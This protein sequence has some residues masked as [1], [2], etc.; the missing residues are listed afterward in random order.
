MSNQWR[1]IMKHAVQMCVF[2][3]I[4][5]TKFNK[6]YLKQQLMYHGIW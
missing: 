4:S 5:H 1:R 2:L 3:D 6:N